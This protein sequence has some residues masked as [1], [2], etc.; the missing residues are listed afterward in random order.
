MEKLELIFVTS[1]VSASVLL[2]IISYI[3][4]NLTGDVSRK[5]LAFFLVVTALFIFCLGYESLRFNALFIYLRTILLL[6]FLPTFYIYI[7]T[8]FTLGPPVFPASLKH[9]I[10]AALMTVL[11]IGMLLVPK[12]FGQDFSILRDIHHNRLWIFI[13]HYLVMAFIFIQL[14][15]YTYAVSKTFPSYVRKLRNYYSNIG[16]FKPRW[17]FWVMG[18]FVAVYVLADIAMLLAVIGYDFYQSVFT[19][20]ITAL[21]LSTAYYGISLAPL[22]FRNKEGEI[23][24]STLSHRIIEHNNPVEKYP[25]EVCECDAKK[26]DFKTLIEALEKLMKEESLYL[27][28]ELNLYDLAATLSTNTN[29]LSKAINETYG[30]NF[31]SYVNRFRIERVITLMKEEKKDNYSLWGLGQ[32]VGFYSKSA[33]IN[34]FKRE[35]GFTPNE[36]LKSV[37]SEDVGI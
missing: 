20:F 25:V 30:I 6:L 13:G 26:K 14:S 7:K 21:V 11:V 19:L 9:F 10:P 22:V 17:L 34:A 2:A 29:Y 35:T 4:Y 3:V 16:P 28:N 1:G 27:N 33:F 36:Y 18:V 32:N 31:N 24:Y 15:A 8:V 23:V 37:K 12:I 5:F